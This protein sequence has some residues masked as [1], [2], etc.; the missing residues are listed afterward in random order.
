MF[1]HQAEQDTLGYILLRKLTVPNKALSVF[2]TQYPNF[3]YLLLLLLP[4]RSPFPSPICPLSSAAALMKA[5][6]SPF[7]LFSI[8]YFFLSAIRRSRLPAT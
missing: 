4:P 6:F 7:L 2:A 5:R 8:L 1:S 3:N